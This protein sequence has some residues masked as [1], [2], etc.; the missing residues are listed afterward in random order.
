MVTAP[1]TLKASTP[2]SCERLTGLKLSDPTIKLAE[3]EAGAFLPPQPNLAPRDIERYK[4]LPA[5]CQVVADLTPSADSRIQMEVWMPASHW[6]RKFQGQGNGGFAGA[7]G[8]NSMSG[9]LEN[10]YATAGTDTG[11]NAEGTDAGWALGHPEK[12]IDFGYWAIHEMT[13]KAKLI[14][15]AYY[16]DPARESYFASCSDGGRE[17]LMEVQRF[18]AD[19]DGILAGAPANY[20]THLVSN[21][22]GLAIE[23]SN[24]WSYIP[25]AKI[26]TI[27]S[28][29]LTACDAQDGVKD[30][31]LSDPRRCH[32]DPALLLCQG[33]ESDAYLTSP[34]VATLKKIYSGTRTSHGEQIF[35][36]YL[37]GGEE[38]PGGW[39]DWILGSAAGES[40]GEDFVNGYFRFMVYD[41]PQWTLGSTSLDQNVQTAD[42][43]CRCAER[44]R[45]GP[46]SV[47]KAGRK[48]DPVSRME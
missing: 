15:G 36:G 33:A 24:P 5:F 27:T 37:P 40:A 19:Y 46:Q 3:M 35:P 4:R 42:E 17:A 28:A 18:P 47:S 32:F 13:G 25:P 45:C 38:G 1:L 14:T 29:V 8:Y 41:D 20:W 21:G 34:Q 11:H 48:T 9:A 16:G 43:N 39:K 6:N 31:F 7:I 23:I 22:S 10:G 44:H 2:V 26:S 30:G 12:V